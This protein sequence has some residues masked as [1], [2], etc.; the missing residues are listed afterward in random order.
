MTVTVIMSSGMLKN[1]MMA[2][3]KNAGSRLGI[4]AISPIRRLAKARAMIREM[5]SIDVKTDC[6]CPQLT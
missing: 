5:V 3:T 6:T 2:H 1:P 4:M